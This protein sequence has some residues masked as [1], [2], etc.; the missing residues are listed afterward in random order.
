MRRLVAAFTLVLALGS[1]PILASAQPSVANVEAARHAF[2]DAEAAFKRGDYEQALTLFRLAFSTAP[3]D[4]VR[5]NIGVCL[6]QLGRYDEAR[7]E[8]EAAAASKTLSP[9]ELA[10][11]H[12]R[13]DALSP[14]TA[15]L[16]IEGG[17]PGVTIAI[18][19]RDRCPLPC[20]LFVL[21][22]KHVVGARVGERD[23]AAEVDAEAGHVATVSL[24]S[25]PPPATAPPPPVV[26]S[27]GR[28]GWLTVVG[29]VVG[30][31][32]TAG[33]IG[34]GVRASDLHA[35]YVA[36]PSADLRDQG[37]VMKGLANGSIGVLSLGA[38]LVVLDL[39]LVGTGAHRVVVADAKGIRVA[40]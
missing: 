23:L 22:G 2:T 5:F 32:G 11:A 31:I 24:A 29:S 38:A 14:L 21:P 34:F 17:S 20:R 8:Y 16:T 7:T 1:L 27:R 33:I 30:G 37:L 13:S 12:R 9:S 39:A 28:A 6:E 36:S 26:T 15:E 25:K 3:R 10:E 35:E 4:A 18:D 40:F 19:H